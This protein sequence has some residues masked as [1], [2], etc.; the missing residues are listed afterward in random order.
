[1]GLKIISAICCLAVLFEIVAIYQEVDG[2]V[3]FKMLH[4]IHRISLFVGIL[5]LGAFAYALIEIIFKAY[6]DFVIFRFS[7]IGLIVMVLV[8]FGS[9]Y[10]RD[11]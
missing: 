7:L 9:R 3:I 10:L 6:T 2:G 11:R 4:T 8:Y 5:F 1:M